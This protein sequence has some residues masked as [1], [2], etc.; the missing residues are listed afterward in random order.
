MIPVK[1]INDCR[2]L[3][4]QAYELSIQIEAMDGFASEKV[5]DRHRLSFESQIEQ[6]ASRLG[7]ELIERGKPRLVTEDNVTSMRG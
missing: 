3:L 1:R 6:V 7:F 2:A 4:R 5:V